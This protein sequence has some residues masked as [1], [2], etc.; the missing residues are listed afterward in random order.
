MS[1][2]RPMSALPQHSRGSFLGARALRS[3]CSRTAPLALL[4]ALSACVEVSFSHDTSPN[5]PSPPSAVVVADEFALSNPATGPAAG[6]QNEP[7][8]AWNGTYYLLVWHDDRS[9]SSDLWF[10][11]VAADG[12]L[13]DSVGERLV[14]NA[15]DPVV[16]S[17]GA[18]FLVVY[19]RHDGTHEAARISA[20]GVLLGQVEI[21]GAHV[22][23]RRRSRI[24]F[25][26]QSYVIA[27]G[28]GNLSY[29][30]VS[31]QGAVLGQG[32]VLVG[33]G[34]DVDLA[35]DG[36]NTLL[37][38]I[39]SADRTRVMG[40]RLS[41][42]G[43]LLNTTPLV[44]ASTSA[45]LTQYHSVGVGCVGGLCTVA[46]GKVDS[47]LPVAMAVEAARVDTQA[48][49]L[50]PQPIV[51]WETDGHNGE[52]QRVQ[53]GIDGQN[54]LLVWEFGAYEYDNHVAPSSLRA[55]RLSPQGTPV[56]ATF[57]FAERSSTPG[58]HVTLA[59]G[60]P[61]PLA[62][63]SD[64]RD[65]FDVI[66]EAHDLTGVRLGANGPLGAPFLVVGA[67]DQR[68]P[69]VAFDGDSFMIAWS[70]GRNGQSG[71]A[72]DIVA[73]RVSPEGDLRDPENLL[74]GTTSSGW[75]RWDVRPAVSTDGENTV[76]GWL[77]CDASEMESECLH[78]AARVSP[79]GAVLDAAP[80]STEMR[81]DRISDARFM[82]P[83]ALLSGDSYVVSVS[84]HSLHRA[85]IDQAGQVTLSFVPPADTLPPAERIEPATVSATASDG[86]NH[87]LLR[88]PA[89][90][91]EGARLSPDGEPLDDPPWFTLSPPG[92]HAHRLTAAFNGAHYVVVW[93]DTT[94]PASRILA[95]RVTPD[96]AVVDP[97]PVVIAEYT[98]CD[99]VELDRQGAVHGAHRTLVAWRACGAN[100]SDLFGAALDADLNVATFRITDDGSPDHAP[101]LAVHDG[102]ILAVY[103]SYRAAAPL[104]AERVYGRFLTEVA[105]AAP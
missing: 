4:L 63:W 80:L 12:T 7:A 79:A 84:P 67:P 52:P 104:A 39:D 61:S 72:T 54:T 102:K 44:I 32:A 92:F 91:I 30:R 59:S 47:E 10:T 97:A 50:D 22:Y 83:P 70:D 26:G 38:A 5:P 37:V 43:V 41:P 29:T 96:G 81:F 64:Q 93:H 53:V 87:L 73:T 69:S 18:D 42:Q 40:Y 89:S 25:D 21:P 60:G 68:H 9:G 62:V 35:F 8:V 78:Q 85:R 48:T 57:T 28:D 77:T 11:R 33:K 34:L 100:S 103:S 23:V 14:A 31:P 66:Y 19:S 58:A 98:G 46:W 24:A 95:M 36:T 71:A 82:S 27:W 55:A 94:P 76:V 49:V 56:G 20:A 88:S 99:A 2:P 101:A 75:L 51:V 16:A 105:P 65:K 90:A 3:L 17:D 45:P 86:T 1:T 6:L 13:L 15:F 74:L